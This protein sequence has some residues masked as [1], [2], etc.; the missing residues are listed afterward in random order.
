MKRTCIWILFICLL[1]ITLT[2]NEV[3]STAQI[4]IEKSTFNSPLVGAWWFWSEMGFLQIVFY[5]TGSYFSNVVWEGTYDV[6]PT[7]IKFATPYG[8]LD[9][10]YSLR[11]DSLWIQFPSGNICFKRVSEWAQSLLRG[12]YCGSSEED[13]NSPYQT[14]LEFDGRG[15]YTKNGVPGLYWVDTD[16]VHLIIASYGYWAQLHFPYCQ[17]GNDGRIIMFVGSDGTFTRCN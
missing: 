9:C 5:P 6:S 10:L 14:V 13:I 15:R 4:P 8:K 11:G 12:K 7:I 16:G 3:R 2:K 1:C 17:F